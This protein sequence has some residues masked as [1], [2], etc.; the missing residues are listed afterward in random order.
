MENTGMK[1]LV[2]ASAFFAAYLVP[3]LMF[4]LSDD[5]AIK[6]LSIQA[7]LFQFVIAHFITI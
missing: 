4:L 7:V 3:I 1:V 2:H 6:K 5:H